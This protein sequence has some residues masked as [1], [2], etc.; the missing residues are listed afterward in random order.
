MQRFTPEIRKQGRIVVIGPRG[1]LDSV[2]AFAFER[3][4]TR[5]LGNAD[6]PVVF[7]CERL[8]FLS[9]SGIR[10][11][12]VAPNLTHVGGGIV[13]LCNLRPHILDVIRLSGLGL[14]SV[15]SVFST[16]PEALAACE[17]S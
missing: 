1:S 17:S 5:A 13:A 11:L 10:I 8:E 12:V 15:L 14:D 9:S 6:V 16:Y 7:D 2:A 4:I 3:V